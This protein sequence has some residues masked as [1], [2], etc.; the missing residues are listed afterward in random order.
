MFLN[1]DVIRPGIHF[2]EARG[3]VKNLSPTEM[4]QLA[5]ALQTRKQAARQAVTEVG[6]KVGPVNLVM[7][8]DELY[9]EAVLDYEHAN[10]EFTRVND[11]GAT[12]APDIPP[13]RQRRQEDQAGGLPPAEEDEADPSAA[14]RNISTGYMNITNDHA[15][16]ISS[17][18]ANPT[19][20]PTA[21]LDRI[22]AAT[23]NAAYTKED[24]RD[25]AALTASGDMYMRMPD[26]VQIY[27]HNGQIPR[28]SLMQ[29]YN[30]FH[31]AMYKFNLLKSVVTYRFMTACNAAVADVLM[32]YNRIIADSLLAY[33]GFTAA[34]GHGRVSEPLKHNTAVAICLLRNDITTAIALIKAYR[35]AMYRKR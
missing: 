9:Y 6:A 19:A 30:H 32:E 2:V 7:H 3:N 4:A 22:A 25:M 31:C 33:S 18:R 23:R 28:E 34:I 16:N 17:F 12:N 1:R 14:G 24:I 15:P 21:D 20:N 27:V 11:S 26:E 35:P 5:A 13:R 29:F 10:A 8:Q